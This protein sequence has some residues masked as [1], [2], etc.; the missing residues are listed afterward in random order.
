MENRKHG[1]ST[2]LKKLKEETAV[3]LQ[4]PASCEMMPEQAL[5]VGAVVMNAN[6]FTLGHLHLLTT[7]AAECRLVH[8]FVVSEDVSLVPFPVRDRL[9]KEGSRHLNNL[10]FHQTGS[11]LISAATFPSYFLKDKETVIRTH[12]RLDTAIFGQIA[13]SLGI[14]LRFIGEEPQS[15]VTGIYNEIMTAELPE[16]GVSCRVIPRKE[17]EGIVISASTVR[18][19]IHSGRI[20][21]IGRLVPDSTLQYFLSDEARHVVR[22]IQESSEV[23]HY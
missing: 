21:S 15:Q 17:S 8:V 22:K 9:I 20:E 2:Y 23:I 1:F 12:A 13:A 18:D 10:V 11:Y 19:R 5:P 4:S 14:S 7:A 6:P 16:S 3:Q